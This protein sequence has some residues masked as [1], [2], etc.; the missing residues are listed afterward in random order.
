MGLSPG[1]PIP[2]KRGGRQWVLTPNGL[3]SEALW[4]VSPLDF[5]GRKQ[6]R[7]SVCEQGEESPGFVILRYFVLF[8]FCFNLNSLNLA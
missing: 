1:A 7:E 8:H 6:E 2:A 3:W 5:T 4:V